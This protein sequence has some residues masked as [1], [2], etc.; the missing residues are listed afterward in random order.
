MKK[1]AV[2]VSAALIAGSAM[3]ADVTVYGVIDTGF[4]YTSTREKVSDNYSDEYMNG[5][6]SSTSEKKFSMDSGNS[7]GSRWGLKGGEDLGNGYKVG[8]KL[9]S[10]FSSDTGKGSDDGLFNRE[11]TLSVSG[12]FGAVYAGRMN[13]L[14]SD[15]G[16]VGWYGAMASPFGSGWGDIAGHYAVMSTQSYKNNS[17]VYMSP[18]FSGL[19]FSAQYSMGDDGSENK[20]S[21]DRYA[22]IGVDYQAGNLEIGF[23]ADYMNKS[24]GPYSYWDEDEDPKEYIDQNAWTI[25]LAAN[26]DCGFA[27]TF[28]AV[29]YFKNVKDFTGVTETITGAEADFWDYDDD[30]KNAYVKDWVRDTSLKGFGVNLG[31]DVPAFGGNV[32]VSIGYADADYRQEKQ[33]IGKLKGYTALAGYQYPFN[34]RTNVYAGAGYTRYKLDASDRSA[35]YKTGKFQALAGLKHTF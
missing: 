20:S 14:I 33:K 28:A 15:G 23:L 29:Q 18:R 27:K 2:A 10:G 22:A 11:A 9:E 24:T 30:D 17:L 4:S 26:Y 32:M 12:P 25:N 19:Q 1:I 3:A 34:K 21:T 6:H 31:V 7:A 35:S 8:F 13:A 16:S 5:Y